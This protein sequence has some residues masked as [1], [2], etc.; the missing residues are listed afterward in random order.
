MRLIGTKLRIECLPRQSECREAAERFSS[1][2]CAMQNWLKQNCVIPVGESWQG[3]WWSSAGPGS[4]CVPTSA[5]RAHG[6]RGE[7]AV[8]VHQCWPSGHVSKDFL[9]SL[10]DFFLLQSTLPLDA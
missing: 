2:R 6:C 7:T 10:S 3:G 4:S 9:V 8:D 1:H 5:Q